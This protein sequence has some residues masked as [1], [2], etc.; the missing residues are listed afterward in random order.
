M[1][2]T[3]KDTIKTR[4]IAILAANGADDSLMKMKAALESKG[5]QTKIVSLKLGTFKGA[6][7]NIIKADQ[8]FF[9][10]VIGII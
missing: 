6:D 7:G 9:R 10:I 2:N 1:A 4:Q 3:I 5:A 8:A